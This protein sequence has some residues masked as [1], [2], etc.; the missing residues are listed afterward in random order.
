[1]IWRYSIYK[2][3]IGDEK[4]CKYID[5]SFSKYIWVDKKRGFNRYCYNKFIRSKFDKEY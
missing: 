4:Y 2:E 1:M 5:T 3:N